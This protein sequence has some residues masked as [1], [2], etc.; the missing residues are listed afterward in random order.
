ML[1]KTKGI[2][3]KSFA[4]GDSS[5]IVKI[6]T[7]ERGLQSFILPGMKSRKKNKQNALYQGLNIL[8]L[9]I[10]QKGENQLNYIREAK[11][12]TLY[13]MIPQD[14]KKTSI[15]FFLNELLYYSIPEEKNTV[16]FDFIESK[17]RMLDETNANLNEFHLVFLKD[18]LRYLGIAPNANH[19][20][21]QAFFNM[22]S[23]QFE[24]V[25]SHELLDQ[26]NS[27]LIAQWLN[28]EKLRRFSLTERQF[29]LDI[30]LQFCHIHIPGFREM[31]SHKILHTVLS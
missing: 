26:Q 21:R 25:Q 5:L 7:R 23:G 11:L 18:Y 16:L 10:Y 17:L 22:Q 19:S 4:Y 28:Q 1:H 31:K 6:F 20:A 13:H 8:E 12:H 27:L 3:L 14:I 9:I 24:M 2:V 29:V 15:L 30:L